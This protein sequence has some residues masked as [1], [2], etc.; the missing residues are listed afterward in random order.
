METP[1][2]VNETLEN[3][4]DKVKGENEDFIDETAFERKVEE[5]L[6]MGYMETSL[7]ND[8][9]IYCAKSGL[10]WA[11]FVDIDDPIKK[12]I[13][14]LLVDNPTTFFV[15]LNTQ[16]GKMRINS[17]EVKKWS[18]DTVKRPVAF[19]VVDNDTTLADQSADGIKNTI[20]ALNVEL[21]TL[22]STSKTTFEDIKRTIDAYESNPEDYKMPVIVLLA[23][24][25]QIE[26]MLK[27]MQH[28]DKKIRKRNSLL[29]YGVIW[30]EA[31]KVYPPFRN[32]IF[33]VGED[34]LSV[35]KF[36]IDN[37]IGL[38]RLGFT[39]ATDGDLLEEEYPE[40]ANA[41]L[42]PVIIDE[43]DQKHYRALHHPEAITRII[44]FSRHN[45]NSYAKE[46][47]SNN[48]ID[49]K[50]K[51]HFPSGKDGYR[52]II[53]NSNSK[54]SEMVEFAN[55]CTEQDMY[56]LVFNG[57]SGA[58]IKVYR[59]GMSKKTFKTKGRKFNEVLFYI[60][61][62]LKLED[63]PLVIIGRR[64]VD[65]GLGFH[66]CPRVNDEVSID[67]PEGILTTKDREG[68][69][70]T[71]MILGKIDDKNIATQK[72]G[73]LAGIIGNS[74]QYPGFICYW[75]DEHTKEI[76]YR[77]NTIV[78][79]ANTYTGCSVLQAV[80]HAE[81]TTPKPRVNHRVDTNSYLVYTDIEEVKKVCKILNLQFKN[82]KPGEDGFITTSNN[83]KSEK[84]SLLDAI[85]KV[86]TGYGAAPKVEEGED[87][88]K[89]SQKY[90][91]IKNGED[92]GKIG[93]IVKK[94]EDGKYEINVEG[95]ITYRD[96]EDLSLISI[97]SVYPSYKDLKNPESI[98]YVI[99]LIKPDIDKT[100]LEEVKKNYKSIDIPQEGKF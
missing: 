25:K 17:L 5:L 38:Y 80:K 37:N 53:V 42:Y 34:T 6:E 47:I 20:G 15:L 32:K 18:E 19:I 82:S 27:L 49:F 24:N 51:I 81:D 21:I 57:F 7:L 4:Y 83:K 23:N 85:K 72:A 2:K 68:L 22:S 70:W 50:T 9:L 65:R 26:K 67:G 71:D 95:K 73:R 12:S 1:Q 90:I 40:C 56:T 48:L 76:I 44:P 31:D 84:V 35:K 77:H 94:N 98:H 16:K 52:K 8:T 100:L 46:I 54:T 36:I 29:R 97:R 62:K 55:W 88:S 64:K 96:L 28:I 3:L 63:K 58:S 43:E 66:Y 99:L 45:N 61:K 91:K 92:K 39:S 69:I 74:P 11:D 87:V 93:I 30:D 41:Y 13:L 59:N 78:D 89:R 10:K 14:L 86:P 75:T 33:Q 60:Y 79:V